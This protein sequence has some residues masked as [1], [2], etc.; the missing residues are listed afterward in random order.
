[1]GKKFRLIGELHEEKAWAAV[2]H[3]SQCRTWVHIDTVGDFLLLCQ[4]DAERVDMAAADPNSRYALPR[5]VTKWPKGWDLHTIASA[6]SSATNHG[7]LEHASS[8]NGNMFKAVSA[9]HHT[10]WSY[11]NT[12]VPQVPSKEIA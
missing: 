12:S 3:L 6:L 4:I 7:T 10:K 2:A 11:T 5:G 9:E 8:P 1:M